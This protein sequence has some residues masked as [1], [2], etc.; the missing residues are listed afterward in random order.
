[1][2]GFKNKRVNNLSEHIDFLENRIESL[3]KDNSSLKYNFKYFQFVINIIGDHIHYQDYIYQQKKFL[4][5]ARVFN[6]IGT[7][8]RSIA[9]KPERFHMSINELSKISATV[10]ILKEESSILGFFDEIK[11]YTLYELISLF[12]LMSQ[13]ESDNQWKKCVLHINEKVLIKHPIK[14]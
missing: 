11:D 3:E 1:M 8:I 9:Q 14:K 10:Q 6:I 13:C 4:I 2:M 7:I 5:T 12:D